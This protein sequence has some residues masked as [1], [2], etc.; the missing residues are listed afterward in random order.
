MNPTPMVRTFVQGFP[1]NANQRLCDITEANDERLYA[2]LNKVCCGFL[3]S[4]RRFKTSP[5]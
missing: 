3:N 5:S 1:Q 4:A 2:G